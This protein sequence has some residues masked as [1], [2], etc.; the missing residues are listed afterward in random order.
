M[1]AAKKL[2]EKIEA[3]PP[4]RIAEIEDFVAFNIERERDRALIRA[5]SATSE[6][7]FAAIWNN[8]KDAAYDGI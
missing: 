6:P 5:A 8:P 4:D 7:A 1:S 2:L 3:L